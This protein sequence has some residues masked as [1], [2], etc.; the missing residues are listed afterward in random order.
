MSQTFHYPSKPAVFAVLMVVSAGLALLPARWTA[1]IDG[2]LQP[3]AWIVSPISAGSRGARS[4][5]DSVGEPAPTREEQEA[6]RERTQWLELQLHHQQ[7]A[8]AEL[9]HMLADVSGLRSQLLDLDSKIIIAPVVG[10]DASPQRETLLIGRG[11]SDGVMIDDWV[12]AGAPP[13]IRGPAVTARAPLLQQWLIGRIIETAPHTSR[14]Q[15]AT[16][17][18]FGRELTWVAKSLPDGAWEVGDHEC[19]LR[20]LG[21]GRMRIEAAPEDYF[22]DSRTVVLLPLAHPRPLALVLGRIV[23]STTLDTGLHYHLEVE[24]WGDA[25]S[26]AYVYVI[27]LSH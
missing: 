14:V 20:G 27:S 19:A 9:E 6:L 18:K 23:S 12:A 22:A 8:T 3:L 4:A 13:Q 5:V 21:G 2:V 17:A 10:G 1:V 26:L 24:P 7:V 11:A 15:L 25:K 16:D